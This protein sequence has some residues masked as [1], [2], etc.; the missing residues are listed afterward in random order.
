M[1]TEKKLL[2]TIKTKYSFSTQNSNFLEK[3]NLKSWSEGKAVKLKQYNRAKGRAN[4]IPC[5]SVQSILGKSLKRQY[6]CNNH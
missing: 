2:K 3:K 5:H 4:N 1:E 6:Q